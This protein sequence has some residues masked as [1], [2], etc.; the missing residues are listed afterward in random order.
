MT[1]WFLSPL[2]ALLVG[3]TATGAKGYKSFTNLPNNV[4]VPENVPLGM[5]VFVVQPSVMGM[6]YTMKP[7]SGFSINDVG[8]VQVS[9]VLDY[10]VTPKPF[11]HRL[12]IRATNKAGTAYTGTLTVVVTN[13]FDVPPVLPS[14]THVVTVKEEEQSSQ[15]LHVDA[16]DV[17]V[18]Y[19]D[20]L[21]YTLSGPDS[22]FFAING[23][24]GNISVRNPI[25]YEAGY[26]ALSVAVWVEDLGGN[27]DHLDITVQ[28]EDVNDNAPTCTPSIVHVTIPENTNNG[29]VVA[30]LVC[31]D[32]DSMT[33]LSC[34]VVS[35]DPSSKFTETGMLVRTDGSLDYETTSSY[36]LT[37]H[38]YDDHN[39]SVRHTTVVTIVIQ[40]EDV[41]D[42]APVW[43]T[44]EQAIPV[45]EAVVPGSPFFTVLATDP[46][47]SP[48]SVITYIVAGGTGKDSF[49]VGSLSGELSALV[50]LDY[51]RTTESYDLELIASDGLH[52]TSSL[53]LTLNVLDVNDNVPEFRGTP[54]TF[55]VMENSSFSTSVGT[56]NAADADGGKNGQFMFSLDVFLQGTP[57]HFTIDQNNGTVSTTGGLDRESEDVYVALV[58]AIDKGQPRQTG[59]A[60]IVI[61]VTDINDNYPVFSAATY[62][63][64]VMEQQVNSS[65]LTVSATDRDI[66]ENSQITYYLNSFLSGYTSH[67][68]IDSSTGA[69]SLNIA[70]DREKDP[71]ITLHV[72]AVDGGT[73]A[74][75]STA[76]VM[77]DVEDVNEPPQWVTTADVSMTEGLAAG[78]HVATVTAVDGD[79]GTGGTVVY[80]ITGITASDGSAS[81]GVFIVS[82]VTG[83]VRTTRVLDCDQGIRSY[84]ITFSAT[85]GLGLTALDNFILT[86]NLTDVNDNS[87]VFG[88]ITYSLTIAENVMI[89]TTVATVSASDADAGSNSFIKYKLDKFLEG[90]P[91]HFS[92]SSNVGVIVTAGRLDRETND[93]YVFV[94]VAQ[95]T[96]VPPLT[97]STTV[98][99]TVTDVNDHAPRFSSALY[100]G[101]VV[102]DAPKG[103]CITSVTVTDKDISNSA[104]V[105]LSITYPQL[106]VDTFTIESGS[107][108]ICLRKTVDREERAF[109]TFTVR[110]EDGG[111][112]TSTTNVTVHVI[113]VNDNP[114]VMC[115]VFYNTE[116][117]YTGVC[118]SSITTVTATDADSG[119]NGQITFF[120]E[121]NVFNYLFS[122]DPD[123]GVFSMKSQAGKSSRYRLTAAAQDGG[124]PSH[125]SSTLA[126]IRVDTLD[127]KEVAVTFRLSIDEA[128]FEANSAVF[129]PTIASIVKI[130]YP[131]AVVKVWCVETRSGSAV[132]P[133]S[134]RRKLLQSTSPVDVHV[135]AVADN[136][137]DDMD[138][139]NKS[140]TFLTSGQ[141]SRSLA[142]DPSGTPVGQLTTGALKYFHIEA[143]TSYHLVVTPWEETTAGIAIIT[144]SVFLA[145]VLIVVTVVV[146]C[147][148]Y[149]RRKRPVSP[150]RPSHVHSYRRHDKK[151]SK[152][153]IFD[154]GYQKKHPPPALMSIPP[155]TY[156]VKP[157]PMKSG[158]D[159]ITSID[160]TNKGGRVINRDFRGTAVDEATGRVYD[161]DART[162]QR[163]WMTTPEGKPVRVTHH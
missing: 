146:I 155:P 60:T 158:E 49:T 86:V 57:S 85:D 96:G 149:K 163:R 44:L 2:M 78:V 71:T 14:T 145:V 162:N 3:C 55:S 115:P 107:G 33:T 120:L 92:I 58:K 50:T 9:S 109:Y 8:Q 148:A 42:T 65:V 83:E 161:Y 21:T 125:N 102:E 25:D 131:S 152:G 124:T 30:S 127:L 139:I 56:V 97:A 28:I 103:T 100:F 51:D 151:P 136:T 40:V 70:V 129:I 31:A 80:R 12:T 4:A 104:N 132:I 113:D 48:G 87:P 24:T 130:S 53:N 134:S 15:I 67:F 157:L 140:K 75:T 137:T 61:H 39:V 59:T 36:T 68:S 116:V 69:I 90:E 153:N 5:T 114:P 160:Y 38:V 99:V 76:T 91:S 121:R 63:G 133:T 138:N 111:S 45:S 37:V 143:V 117:A 119:E 112:L 98:S 32:V 84:N 34:S 88:K 41:D 110:A 156:T 6:T 29:T 23:N 10:D 81:S 16:T 17:E 47:T 22:I 123:S 144:V 141:L 101:Q 7:S 66:G 52:N 126:V 72:L 94:V 82:A 26:H 105:T 108:R 35:G 64:S 135:Y 73:P 43:V 13:I 19:G 62:R 93:R 18:S 1:T 54:Y 128:A 122:I 106:A 95:D 118:G 74:F 154:I 89:G 46:D 79:F 27:T 150:H 20:K 147:Y 142:S 11:T 159:G 77:I